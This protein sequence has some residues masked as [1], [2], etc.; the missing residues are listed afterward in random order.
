MVRIL[1]GILPLLLFTL[2]VVG[3]PIASGISWPGLISIVSAQWERLLAAFANSSEA[4]LAGVVIA[5]FLVGLTVYLIL[6]RA[7]IWRQHQSSLLRSPPS[8]QSASDWRPKR[9][10]IASAAEANYFRATLLHPDQVYARI[11]QHVEPLTRSMLI[12]SGISI[13][14]G[15]LPASKTL[16]LPLMMA[17][18]GRLTSGLAITDASGDRL[19][20]T[21]RS[22][23]VA[24]AAR[25]VRRLVLG[26]GIAPYARYLAHSGGQSIEERVLRIF[27][28]SEPV[29]GQEISDVSTELLSLAKN[30]SNDLFEIVDIVEELAR[31]Y[32]ICIKIDATNANATETRYNLEYRE[33]PPMAQLSFRRAFQSAWAPQLSNGRNPAGATRRF[34]R[35]IPRLIAGLAE[36]GLAKFRHFMGIRSNIVAHRLEAASRSGSYHLQVRGPE[37]TY[38]ASQELVLHDGR[39]APADMIELIRYRTTDLVAQRNGHLY[40]NGPSATAQDVFLRVRFFETTPGSMAR[41]LI[42]SLS[43]LGLVIVIALPQLR[44]ATAD[45]IKAGYGVCDPTEQIRIASDSGLLQVLLVFPLGL[46]LTALSSSTMWGGVLAARLANLATIGLGFL[47]L[48]VSAVPSAMSLEQL[49]QVWLSLGLALAALSLACFGSWVVRANSH[50]RYIGSS[51]EEE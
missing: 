5:L 51:S 39:P 50:A 27:A 34:L 30:R 38:I 10:G 29:D 20:S 14:L 40:I 15:V 25:C 48:F 22:E 31:D 19:P 9:L 12:R 16:I 37:N 17:R 4:P 49:R 46:A 41:A 23:Y 28:S 42:A 13:R 35:G 32:P 24:F 26:L 47:A 33:S 3:I 45:C 6:Q 1:R 11:T 44:D 21:T 36:A 7:F 8:D 2:V 43:T 18:R